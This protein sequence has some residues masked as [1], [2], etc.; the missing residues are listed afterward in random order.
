MCKMKLPVL[1]SW[2]TLTHQNLAVRFGRKKRIEIV[3]RRYSVN[4]TCQYDGD[5]DGD[6]DVWS[7]WNQHFY[8]HQKKINKIKDTHRAQHENVIPEHDRISKE[9]CSEAVAKLA[10][11][12]IPTWNNVLLLLAIVRLFQSVWVHET[13]VRYTQ[14]RYDIWLL[15]HDVDDENRHTRERTENCAYTTNIHAKKRKRIHIF[16]SYFWHASKSRY[17]TPNKTIYSHKTC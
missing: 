2:Y 1:H 17:F 10:L 9:V 16:L 11:S 7:R 6:D 13:C 8:C 15:W 5:D 12:S 14:W 3:S 4:K